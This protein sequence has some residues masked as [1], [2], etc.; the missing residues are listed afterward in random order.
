LTLFDGGRPQ[1][2]FTFIDDIVSGV[3]AATRR[4]AGFEVINLGRGAPVSM[5]EFVSTL[6]ELTGRSALIKD[7]P[8]PP[9]DAPVTYADIGKAKRLLD[10]EPTTSLHDGLRKLVEWYVE[11]RA[12][13]MAVK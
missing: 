12:G 1:R 2:D 3:V 8:L 7:A 4:V 10:Y 9:S 6:E 5:R 13:L 11:N